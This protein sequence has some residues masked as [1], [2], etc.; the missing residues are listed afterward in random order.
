LSGLKVQRGEDPNPRTPQTPMRQRR[1]ASNKP[2][3][4]GTKRK[5]MGDQR[6]AIAWG[7]K[8]CRKGQKELVLR[9]SLRDIR[10]ENPRSSN[11]VKAT[12]CS[13]QEKEVRKSVAAQS[14]ASATT[15]TRTGKIACVGRGVGPGREKELK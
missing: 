5:K 4:A 6:A 10:G 15:G 13:G 14:R 9:E 1:K 2:T 7:K 11:N 12:V 8:L 3:R